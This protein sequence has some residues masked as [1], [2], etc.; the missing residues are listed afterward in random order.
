[1]CVGVWRQADSR[2]QVYALRIVGGI[3]VKDSLGLFD[4]IETSIKDCYE[5]VPV[6]RTDIRGGLIKTFHVPAFEELGLST[7]F[8]EEFHTVSKKNVIRAMHFQLPP[9]AYVKLAYCAS[10]KVMAAVLDLRKNS[11]TR[12]KFHMIEL[13]SDRG[14]EFY[15]PIGVAFGYQV[16]TET[17]VVVYKTTAVFSGEHD[18]GVRWDSAGIHWTCDNPIIAEKDKHLPTLADFESP[19]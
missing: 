14:N 11:P 10:G 7:D 3:I 2:L 12:G 17:A 19:F 4:K 9:E 8:K 1:M 6:V 15:I 18:F 13:D 16:L 5:I